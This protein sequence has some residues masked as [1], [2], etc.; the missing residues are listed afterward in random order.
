MKCWTT[1]FQKWRISTEYFNAR[2][3]TVKSVILTLLECLGNYLGSPSFSSSHEREVSEAICPFCFSWPPPPLYGLACCPSLRG[4]EMRTGS[5]VGF[6]NTTVVGSVFMLDREVSTRV[7]QWDNHSFVQFLL[8]PLD[9]GPAQ[10]SISGHLLGQVGECSTACEFLHKV[11]VGRRAPRK[12]ICSP[13]NYQP[14][15]NLRRK[16]K[17]LYFS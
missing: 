17:N 2:Q 5:S 8:P 11:P 1:D 3:Q 9:V 12:R 13:S 7:P 15:I 16:E 6:W 14:L 4:L 10:L